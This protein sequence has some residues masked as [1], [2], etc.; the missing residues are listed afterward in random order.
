MAVFDEDV[1]IL[2]NERIE[3]EL[4]SLLIVEDYDEIEELIEDIVSKLHKAIPESKR[5]S[6]GITYVVKT[7]SK[8]LFEW[9]GTSEL[10]VF[11]KA[12]MLYRNMK[13]FRTKCVGLGVLSHYG[14]N[15]VDDV[16]PYFKDA[17]ANEMWEIREFA[18]MYIRKITKKHPY[19][20]QEFLI[21][22]TKSDDPN[23]RRYA[24][25]S[26][27]PVVENRWIINNPEFSLKVLRALFEESDPYPRVSVGN[28][29]SDLSRSLPELIFEIVEELVKSGNENSYWIAKRACR[30]LIMKDPIRVMN[31][32]GV[33]TYVYKNRKYER[34]DYES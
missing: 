31:I 30:N 18:Q 7:L 8:Y 13:S 32:L 21:N 17:A 34:S 29:L 11:E 1:L 24:S 26:L 27:R 3:N 12:I 10:D 19:K 5:V 22:L 2:M 4:K 28:N 6:Y 20:V 14:V 23:H 15:N 25:E 33:D 16:L 9:L